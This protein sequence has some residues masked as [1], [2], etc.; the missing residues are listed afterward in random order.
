MA[1]FER[2]VEEVF[3]NCGNQCFEFL[4]KI[5][6]A[7]TPVL[8]LR[9][10][11]GDL[12]GNRPTFRKTETSSLKTSFQDRVFLRIATGNSHLIRQS[13]FGTL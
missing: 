2:T 13:G 1:S 8:R 6:H 11:P 4:S 5:N 10:L 12:T 3:Y 9:P 7:K